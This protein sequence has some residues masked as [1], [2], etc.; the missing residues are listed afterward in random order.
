MAKSRRQPELAPG[1]TGAERRRMEGALRESEARYRALFEQK[2]DGVVVFGEN[3]K[4]LLANRASAE[5]L[6]FDSVEELLEVNLFDY[7]MP[8]EKERVFRIIA[9]DM[10]GSD[11]R[12]VNE[13]RCVKKSGEE[14]W[15]SAIGSLIEYQ[16]KPAGLGS[17]RD[18]TERRR[19]E[20]ALRES[21]KKYRTLFEKAN[22][23]IFLVDAE[24]GYVADA[25][26]E[27]EQLLGRP[28]EEI[29]ELHQSELHHPEQA[30]YHKE[31]FREHAAAGHAS[32]FEAEVMRKDGTLVPVS[33]SVS[34]VPL[35]GR[36][37]MQGIFRDV[38]ERKQ[39][40]AQLIAYQ[41]EL[42][43]LA[44][45][46][47]LAEERERRRLA[48][49]LHDQ[50]SQDLAVCNMKLGVLEQ[51]APAFT[52]P[53]GEI[54][55]IIKHLIEKTRSL[56]FELSSPL[57]YELGLEAALQQL[58][59]QITGRGN[60]RCQ[61]VSDGH[62][63]PLDGDIRILLFQT[64]R[65][66][67]VNVTK[68][69]RARQASVSIRQYDDSIRITVEDDGVGFDTSKIGTDMKQAKGFGLFGIR[70]RLRYIGGQIEVESERGHGTRVALDVPLRQGWYWRGEWNEHTGYPG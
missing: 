49:E 42:R 50:L 9:E 47:S 38:T 67:L 24:T 22:D 12:Q 66:L 27:A 20:E 51:S 5:M 39:A 70:E 31:K 54:R 37:L 52:E 19:A 57:L 36:S 62:P 56:S 16:G 7:V 41:M 46:L 64:V 33:I 69:A 40:E 21:E 10:F 59:E 58:A 18:V 13:F 45:Q 4:M 29:L 17:F 14:I 25:N 63:K 1:K 23:A 8:E 32:D 48:M 65:E 60:I 15:I 43:S 28:R 6:G 55:T 34:V 2:L 11:L 30:E 44:S 53:L 3:M 68:H 26:R 61:F 35:Q